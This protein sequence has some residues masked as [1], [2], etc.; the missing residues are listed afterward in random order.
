MSAT[1]PRSMRPMTISPTNCIDGPK[2]ICGS[3]SATNV[4]VK[5]KRAD[6]DRVLLSVFPIATSVA[7]RTLSE[8]SRLSYGS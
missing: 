1:Q 7:L 4:S 5:P 6:A 3:V 8:S 2:S